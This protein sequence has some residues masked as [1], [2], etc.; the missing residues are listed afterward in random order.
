MEKP[1]RM[2]IMQYCKKNQYA[3]SMF[4]MPQLGFT[5]T[6]MVPRYYLLGLKPQIC[7]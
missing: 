4:D 1:F 6:S 5:N 2:N 3:D 7:V